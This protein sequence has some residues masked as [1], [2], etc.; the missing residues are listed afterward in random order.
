MSARR[1]AAA[2]PA[3]LA[4]LGAVAIAGCATPYDYGPYLEHMP[5][6]IVVLPPTNESIE[7]L[8]PYNYLSTVSAPLAERGYYVFP[9][10]VVDELLK[11]NGLPTPEE[12]QTADLAKI[13]EVLGADAVLYLHV[14]D[15]GTSYQVIASNTTVHV[16]G[17]LVDARTGLVLW[18]GTHV[19]V[20]SSA[21]GQ[22]NL[23]AMIFTAL[24][25]QISDTTTDGAHALAGPATVQWIG[26]E[27]HGLLLGPRHPG[28]QK[29]IDAMKH[30]PAPAGDLPPSASPESDA[31]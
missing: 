6:S 18:Q 12:M 1:R 15:W 16:E 30:E 5:R 22:S 24:V 10:A 2:A 3:A 29:Q 21:E 23:V 20:R 28:F 14:K 11:Q 19:A 9:V 13:H 7:P 27:G 8:A 17:R 4:L 31:N 26:A 25:Q